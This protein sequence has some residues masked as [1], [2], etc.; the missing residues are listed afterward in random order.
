MSTNNVGVVGT[1]GGQ[2]TGY[3]A[4]S[5][6]NTQ[7]FVTL[8]VTELE[9]Q[10]PMQPMDN[11]QMLQEVS[12]IRQIESDDQTHQHHGLGDDGAEPGDRQRAIEQADPRYGRFGEPGHGVVNK[13]SVEDGAIKVYVGDQVVSLSNVAQ[14]LSD[15]T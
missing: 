4:F 12:Q 2:A 5:N 9:Q 8:L 13:V 11:S 3:D 15:G 10:D 7:D 1:S 6:L 14:I